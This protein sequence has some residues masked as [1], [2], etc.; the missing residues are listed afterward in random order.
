MC[1]SLHTRCRRKST[2]VLKCFEIYTGV[3][4]SSTIAVDMRCDK[5]AQT[6]VSVSDVY[7]HICATDHPAGLVY[8]QMSAYVNPAGRVVS[9][10][11]M[12]IHTAGCVYSIVL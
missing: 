1:L 5:L 4:T 7:R 3:L 6:V 8:M 10:T 11:K 12:A 2:Y 9:S